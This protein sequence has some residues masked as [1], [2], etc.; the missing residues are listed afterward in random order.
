MEERDERKTINEMYRR[1]LAELIK[2]IERAK[3]ENE[4]TRKMQDFVI[5]KLTIETFLGARKPLESMDWLM[6]G[7]N[8]YVN[9]GKEI[10]RNDALTRLTE[11]ATNLKKIKD[12][13]KMKEILKK[14]EEHQKEV[15]AM[16][17][18]RKAKPFHFPF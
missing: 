9:L 13:G 3:K 4:D 5:E 14:Y 16:I 7:I 12:P 15:L 17:K 8:H 10:S 1:V 18:T 11:E 6:E 2:S